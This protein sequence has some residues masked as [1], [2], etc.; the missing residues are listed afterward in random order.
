MPRILFLKIGFVLLLHSYSFAQQINQ[1]RPSLPSEEQIS[2]EICLIRAPKSKST[3][4]PPNTPA[5]PSPQPNTPPKQPTE[6]PSLP[7]SLP[8]PE[9]LT[10]SP[11]R[12]SLFSPGE[13]LAS[14]FYIL[15]LPPPFESATI[16]LAA[17]VRLLLCDPSAYTGSLSP[18]TGS[19][20][21]INKGKLTK[22]ERI[23]AR[24]GWIVVQWPTREIG[25]P[26]PGSV[27]IRSDRPIIGLLS[28]WS[29]TLLFGIDIPR[30]LL[31]VAPDWDHSP[32]RL[33]INRTGYREDLLPNSIQTG[34]R[35]PQVGP[36]LKPYLLRAGKTEEDIHKLEGGSQ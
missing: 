16:P 8:V 32:R 2:D 25:A 17:P 24:N 35:N 13:S 28:L 7:P 5:V 9:P 36:L 29:D 18:W 10:E 12:T 1:R 22:E 15:R 20:V 34:L 33:T 19:L 6:L 31:K 4:L 26:D 14:V 11:N 21:W 23:T 27:T 3:S 30:L